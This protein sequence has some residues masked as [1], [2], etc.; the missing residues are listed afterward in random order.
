[1]EPPQFD[2]PVFEDAA[3]YA[4]ALI[5]LC[6]SPYPDIR[7]VRCYVRDGI[8]RLEGR[9]PTYHQK[10]LAQEIVS[11][12]AGVRGVQNHIV[13]AKLGDTFA[14]RDFRSNSQD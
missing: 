7:R 6:E 11:R 2:E 12:T 5:S 9:L 13:V 1:M 10:Q 14:A 4:P 8:A 3:E